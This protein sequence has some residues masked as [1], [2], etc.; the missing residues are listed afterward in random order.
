MLIATTTL[1]LGCDNSTDQKL[2]GTWVSGQGD[3]IKI[4]NGRIVVADGTQGR[5]QVVSDSLLEISTDS[6]VSMTYKVSAL[7]NDT[8]KLH[9]LLWDLDT[10]VYLK[11]D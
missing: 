6:S 3:T 10:A 4:S 2:Q 8:L 1:L 11:A 7:N 9:G 5:Y